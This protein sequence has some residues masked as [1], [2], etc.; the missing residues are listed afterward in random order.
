MTGDVMV[1]GVGAVSCHG[2]GADALWK[3]M[4][5]AATRRPDRPADPPARM[6]RPLIHLAPD[7][8]LTG[9]RATR[10]ATAA[11]SEAWRDAGLGPAEA[12]GI[13]VVVGSCMGEPGVNERDRRGDAAGQGWLPPFRLASGVAAALGVIGPAQDI[14]NACAAG[15]YAIGLAADM[16]RAGEASVVVAGGA[17]AYSRVALGCF[18]RLG[19]V[20]PQRCR[21][22]DR[23]R[24]GTVFAEG[25]AMLVLESREHAEARGAAVPGRGLRLA[26]AAWSCDAGH[27]T[28]PEPEAGQI[29]R[30]MTEALGGSADGVGCVVPHGTGTR[31]NDALESRALHR[32]LG[33]RA[34]RVPVYS[35]KALLGHAGG[36]SGALG[37][38]AAAQILRHGSVPPNVRLD[39]QDPECE[40]SLPQDGPV[41]LD[42]RRALVNAYGFGGNNMSLVLEAA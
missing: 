16:I 27:P 1:T 33:S 3:A 38:V 36:A 42:G 23:H 31:L 12:A 41:P 5:D 22:F 15:G 14:A 40:V 39:E 20:D 25:A 29:V 6:D 32:V 37:A 26:G 19:A 10:F 2:T 35:L 11:A 8:D 18:N 13:A 34:G 9:A 21:P 28:A 17:D 30:A 7:G 4:T 24:G